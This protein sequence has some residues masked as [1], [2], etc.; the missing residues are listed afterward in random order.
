MTRPDDRPLAGLTV[1][2][3]RPV[4]QAPALAVLLEAAGA[5]PFVMPLIDL[6][7]VATDE[8][9]ERALAGLGPDDWVVATSAHAARRVGPAL[10]GCVAR[11]AAVG[12]T[13]AATLPRVDLVAEQQ[14]ADGLVALF[15]AGDGRVIVAQAEEGA[16]TMA[17]GVAALGWRAERLHTHRS[18]PVVPT[19]KQQLTVLA[20]DA[21]VFTSGTQA[22]AW[23]NIFGTT[24]PA[25]VAT[26][27]PQTTR[28]TEQAG[29]K[30]QVTAADHSL[31][32]LVDAM[33]DF[34]RHG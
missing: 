23:V 4:D 16:P 10:L 33:E 20:A 30:V 28:K 13:T 21:V 9:I 26:I 3:T 11:V 32:G 12:A 17:D 15:P 5:R 29:I 7:D 22:V 2:I 24:T 18:V 19:A 27:G 14:S 25:V 31:T 8:E 34:L 1:V 6:A